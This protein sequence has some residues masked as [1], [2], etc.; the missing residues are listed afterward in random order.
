MV[1]TDFTKNGDVITLQLDSNSCLNLI[2][3]VLDKESYIHA[4]VESNYHEQSSLFED[5]VVQANVNLN[6][7]QK[8]ENELKKVDSSK[9]EKIELGENEEQP[10]ITYNQLTYLIDKLVKRFILKSDWSRFSN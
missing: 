5:H 3:F 7:L 2:S 1:Y 8:I 9:I 6:D 4:V 10:I